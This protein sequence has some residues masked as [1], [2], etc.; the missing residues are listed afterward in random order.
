MLNPLWLNTFC[1]LAD[2]GHFTRTADKLH[3]TQPG[4]SQH[5]KKLE[6]MCG[7]PLLKREGKSIELTE[8]GRMVYAFAMKQKNDEAALAEALSF[9][10]PHKGLCRFACSG[11]LALKLYP[12]LI[13]LQKQHPALV[14]HLEAAPNHKILDDILRGEIDLGIVTH[15]PTLTQFRFE[16]LAQEPLCLVLPKAYNQ[17]TINTDTLFQLGLIKHPDAN[18]YLSAYFDGCGDASLQGVVADELPVS[19]YVN[20]LNLI[21]LPV[22][23]GIGFTVL[24]KSA[25]DQFE[26]ANQLHVHVPKQAVTEQLYLVQKRNRELPAR[27]SILSQQL[28]GQF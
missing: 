28:L 8:Q 4:V 12:E 10:D 26:H 14:T 2:I 9:D 19:S 15:Q 22:A 7:Y 20:Q 5:I 25:V 24:P 1:T 13:A 17:Q 16:E 21:L 11:A 27:Y 23:Q 18:H 3:M 6:Q